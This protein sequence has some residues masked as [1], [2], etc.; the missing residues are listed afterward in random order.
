MEVG[1]EARHGAE[2]GVSGTTIESLYERIQADQT[3]VVNQLCEIQRQCT[4]IGH[5]MDTS[6]LSCGLHRCKQKREA[7]PIHSEGYAKK[8]LMPRRD[9]AVNKGVWGEGK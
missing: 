8:S 9:G 4:A 5:R 6:E 3:D 1:A 7:L 2:Y